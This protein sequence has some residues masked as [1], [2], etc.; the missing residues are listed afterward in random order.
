[1]H[2]AVL[3]HR[4]VGALQDAWAAA[5]STPKHL[6][7][8]L[9]QNPNRSLEPQNVLP[10]FYQPAT[11][12]QLIYIAKSKARSSPLILQ[13]KTSRKRLTTCTTSSHA[14]DEAERLSNSVA[15]RQAQHAS[16]PRK[17][18]TYDLTRLNF[19]CKVS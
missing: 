8:V 13:A 10:R 4:M 3:Q 2:E 6:T 9:H 16:R 19:L 5:A 14:I 1:M 15:C 17:R 11:V 7:N 18:S 12:F